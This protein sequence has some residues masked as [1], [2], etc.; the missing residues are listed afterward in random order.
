MFDSLLALKW[1]RLI[2]SLLPDRQF[3]SHNDST[4]HNRTI[5]LK[6]RKCNMQINVPCSLCSSGNVRVT[7]IIP[8]LIPDKDTPD[9]HTTMDTVLEDKVKP[10]ARGNF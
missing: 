2:I 10:K 3:T 7:E 5:V 6:D 4:S 1:D 9:F 8:L